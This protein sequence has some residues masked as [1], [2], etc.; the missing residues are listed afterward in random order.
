MGIILGV[1]VL[2]NFCLFKEIPMA[3]K[4]LF[5]TIVCHCVHY[6]GHA[7]S[8]ED[9]QESWR[10]LYH[11]HFLKRAEE[12]AH[13]CQRGFVL[14]QHSPEVCL[15]SGGYTVAVYATCSG[16]SILRYSYMYTCGG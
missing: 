1:N 4:G 5:I 13:K 16:N 11:L 7:A 3:S 6:S 15:F 12:T 2:Y 14:R 8:E 10:H 9:I